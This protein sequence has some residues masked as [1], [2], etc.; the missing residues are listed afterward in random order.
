MWKY[1]RR[2]SIFP[3]PYDLNAIQ[4]IHFISIN[5]LSAIFSG[6]QFRKTIIILQTPEILPDSKFAPSFVSP[7][8]KVPGEYIRSRALYK[9]RSPQFGI[10]GH[11]DRAF[12]K[13]SDGAKPMRNHWRADRMDAD[14]PGFVLQTETAIE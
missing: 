4:R 5:F 12:L 3:M 2:F 13:K 1:P 9:V 14:Q 6:V 7:H 10:L 8:R 11:R